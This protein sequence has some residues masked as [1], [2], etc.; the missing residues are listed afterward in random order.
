M[1]GHPLRPLSSNASLTWLPSEQ[2]SRYRP[3][4]VLSDVYL[5][6]Q[7]YLIYRKAGKRETC[8]VVGGEHVHRNASRKVKQIRHGHAGHAAQAVST[9]AD[10]QSCGARICVSNSLAIAEAVAHPNR[11][12]GYGIAAKLL[13]QIRHVVQIELR[14]DEHMLRDE[15][16]EPDPGMHLKVIHISHGLR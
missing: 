13:V 6:L 4:R 5:H 15:Q 16:L 11:G 1:A 9:I 14:P 8:L 3:A 7:G 2:V 12:R 10:G